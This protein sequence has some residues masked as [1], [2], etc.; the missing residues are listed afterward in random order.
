MLPSIELVWL[1]KSGNHLCALKIE[2]ETEEARAC[3]E[4]RDE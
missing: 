3:E 4:K 2:A 1:Y